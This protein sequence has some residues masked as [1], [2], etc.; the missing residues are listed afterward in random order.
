MTNL[1]LSAAVWWLSYYLALRSIGRL[2]LA[3][4]PLMLINFI[5]MASIIYNFIMLWQ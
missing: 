2:T 3:I 5:S 1:L 4:L